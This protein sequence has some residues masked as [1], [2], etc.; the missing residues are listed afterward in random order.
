MGG[1][2]DPAS[3]RICTI[4]ALG[5]FMKS[6]RTAMLAA[7]LTG[8]AATPAFADITGFIGADLTPKSRHTQGFAVGGGLMILGFEFEY[9]SA[10]E[11]PASHAPSLN[12]GMGNMLLQAPFSIYGFQPYATAGAGIYSETLGTHNEKNVGLNTGGG[13]KISLV[14][15]VRLRLDYRVF[16]LNGALDSPVHRVYVG[17]NL[18]F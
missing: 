12:S 18:K 8:L 1:Q 4:M 3:R 9:A 14:G 13:V 6:V 16:K 2:A 10:P 7:V 17:L 15:P 5:G 11:D